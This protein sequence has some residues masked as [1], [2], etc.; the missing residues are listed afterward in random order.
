ML[1]CSVDNPKCSLTQ[2]IEI[3][4]IIYLNTEFFVVLELMK[5]YTPISKNLY[6]SLQLEAL[7]L[8]YL[9]LLKIGQI[10]K[11]TEQIVTALKL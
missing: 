2:P 9:R 10:Q 1:L 3:T 5:R 6:A 8:G 7:H 4:A 11:I